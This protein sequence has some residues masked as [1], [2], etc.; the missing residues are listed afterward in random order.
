MG[1]E[2]AMAAMRS[3][4]EESHPEDRDDPTTLITCRELLKRE[5]AADVIEA[6]GTL[7]NKLSQYSILIQ[8]QVSGFSYEP[9]L[10][11]L[12]S[13]ARIEDG[14]QVWS[15]VFSV[16]EARAAYHESRAK[17]AEAQALQ[18]RLTLVSAGAIF[19]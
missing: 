16:E 13:V 2:Q 7:Y 6:L 17:R 3:E 12:Y 1:T 4:E 11:S 14:G 15:E 19:G 9:R 5:K 10:L 8:Q 18:K